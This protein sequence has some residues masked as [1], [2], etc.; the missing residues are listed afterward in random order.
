MRLTE[1]E[2]HWFALEDG[3]PAVGLSFECPHCRKT[4]LGIAFHHDGHAAMEDLYIRAHY[5]ADDKRFIW[6]LNGQADFA[7]LTLTPSIDASAA[8]HWHGFITN[9]EI[10]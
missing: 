4:R 1:L 9:G 3:G 5:P 2:P 10:R 6:N 7:T 8:G